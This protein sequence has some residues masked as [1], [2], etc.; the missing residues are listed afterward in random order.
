MFLWSGTDKENKEKIYNS[1]L[2]FS[3]EL[4][5]I[6]ACLGLFVT[7]VVIIN[8]EHCWSQIGIYA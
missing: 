6:L 3:S 5:E 4:Y 2:F 8:Y 7:H 1:A